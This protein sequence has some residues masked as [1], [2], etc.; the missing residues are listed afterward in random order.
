MEFHKEIWRTFKRM[1][2]PKHITLHN[3][4]I[5]N[6]KTQF[7]GNN[8]I[9]QGTCISSSMIGRN[10]YIDSNCDL[11][12]SVIGSFCSLARNIKVIRFNHPSHTFV[13]TSPVFFSTLGQTNQT[14]VSE[15]HF[16]E[17]LTINGRSVIIGNDVWIGEDV[18][19][20]GG[21]TIGD[22]AIVAMGAVVAKDVPPYAIVG[23]VP[24]KIIKYRFS[25]D[26]IEELLRIK[27]WTKD[28]T[29]LKENASC[30]RNI[31]DFIRLIRNED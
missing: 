16:D 8:V 5:F 10:T 26:V 27:W 23:G 17:E 28:D 11:P 18:K 4:V 19:I 14:Y 25:Q 7:G 3:A 9:H 12:N 13:S 6:D 29:W 22:G 24:A 1:F 15:N 2:L 20:K 21:V 30:F 31:D